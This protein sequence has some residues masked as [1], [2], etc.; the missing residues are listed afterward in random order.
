MMK[1]ISKR[2]DGTFVAEIDGLPYHVTKDDAHF[3]KAI[4]LEKNKAV[5]TE[6]DADQRT[7]AEKADARLLMIKAECRR[8]IYAQASIETQIN[9][10]T[11][12]AAISSKEPSDRTAEENAV[13]VGVQAALAWVQEMRSKVLVLAANPDSDFYADD[14]WP[15]PP[16]AAKE[17]VA[18]F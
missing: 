2:G 8:R 18:L 5:P 13:V 3:D 12:L 1:L 4:I 7:D 9:F 15:E 17:M 16:V 11:A 10:S 14:E 6:A